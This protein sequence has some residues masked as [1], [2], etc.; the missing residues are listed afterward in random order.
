VRTGTVETRTLEHI[1]A[2][3]TQAV[4]IRVVD[5]GEEADLGRGHGIV[6]RKEELEAEDAAFV[7]GLSGPM[8]GDVE[9]AEVVFVWDRVDSRDPGCWV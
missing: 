8:D 2:D 3:P 7:R 9:I 1:Q 5:L 6:F 4:D